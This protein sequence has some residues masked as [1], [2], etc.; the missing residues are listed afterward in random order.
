MNILQSKIEHEHNIKIPGGMEQIRKLFIMPDSPDKFMEFGYELLDLIHNFFK[1]KGGIHSE[2]PLTE[3]AKIFSNIE[4]PREPQLWRT[5]LNE[6]KNNIIAHSVKVG[7]PYYVGHMT[8]AIPYFM[9]LLEMIIAALNQNQVKIET[10]KAS[11]YVERELIG[12]IHRL[13]FNRSPKYYRQ[14]VQNR[15]YVLGN[16]TVDGTIANLTA[17]LV[18]RNRAFPPDGRFP[19]IRKAGIYDAFRYY[20]CNRAVI[21]VSK[22]GHYSIDKIAWILGLGENSVIKI[23]V[24]A[25]NKIDVDYLA[26]ELHQIEER[27]RY[28]EEKIKIIALVGIAGTTETGNVDNL[29]AL[30]ELA[31]RYETHFHVDA[32]WGGPLLLVDEY[33]H[34][35][36]GIELA[37]TVT[38]DA[39]KLLYSP[40]SMGMVLFR[41]KKLSSFL[42]H[43][44]NYII[45]EDSVDQGRFTVEGS[46]PFSCLKPWVTLKLFGQEGFRVLFGHASML[47]NTLMNLVEK[48]ENFERMNYP[49][50][51]IFNYRFVPAKVQQ[52]LRELE[53]DAINRDVQ[54]G[55]CAKEKI[56][57]INHMLNQLN[58][59][60]HKAIR[61]EDNSFVSRTMLESTRYAPQKIV[62]LRAVTVNPLTTPEILKE[63]IDE[64]NALGLK[65]YEKEF[66][67]R[68]ESV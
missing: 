1:E 54:G 10:A 6:I 43:T 55:L 50:L 7:N 46:R 5:I 35:F 21:F 2:I 56:K 22:R 57:K 27:N 13:I 4:I 9:I 32:A 58:V 53:K 39:H 34:L 12:W 26:R 41:S 31:D 17:L 51:F 62:V 65:L 47:T 45:R 60:L 28:G 8:S 37:D 3:L 23:P 67:N 38:F 49:E 24:D 48:H 20:H 40:L 11:T 18:A 52:K 68:I 63:I 61:Q 16:V 59:E 14:N 36:R 44:S 66:K 30:Y 64:H 29:M 33:R 25:Y 15:N 42:F 19:G